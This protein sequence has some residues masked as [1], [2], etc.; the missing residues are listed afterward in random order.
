MPKMS[1]RL[2]VN[3]VALSTGAAVVSLP[4]FVEA[5]RLMR[6]PSRIELLSF[7]RVVA[8]APIT[9]KMVDLYL[10]DGEPIEVAIE[11]DAPMEVEGARAL[12]DGEVHHEGLF[13]Q[14]PKNLLPGDLLT[15]RLRV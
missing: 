11:I 12:F 4:A 14:G 9:G 7:G 15:V 1:R 13:Q 2:F 8:V 5:A 3:T 6:L 10:R